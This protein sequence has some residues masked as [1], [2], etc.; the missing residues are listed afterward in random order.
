MELKYG[1]NYTDGYHNY[2]MNSMTDFSKLWFKGKSELI[3]YINCLCIAMNGNSFALHDKFPVGIGI[4]NRNFWKTKLIPSNIGSISNVENY[5]DREKWRNW[6]NYLDEIKTM[7]DGISVYVT[8]EQK[9]ILAYSPQ[10]DGMKYTRYMDVTFWISEEYAQRVHDS[11]VRFSKHINLL[12]GLLKH[13][14]L[15]CTGIN[16][17]YAHIDVGKNGVSFWPSS[18]LDQTSTRYFSEFQ[19]K[20]LANKF[21]CFVFANVLYDYIVDQKKNLVF[22][23]TSIELAHNVLISVIDTESAY[24]RL[25]I[26]F[27]QKAEN[28]NLNCW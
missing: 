1:V 20:P 6:P 14:P 22:Y 4:Y 10:Y 12:E 23:D 7:P 26:C 25:R 17:K 13:T 11:K 27:S 8:A 16:K 18:V 24:V 21:E 2:Y 5:H 3:E 9:S 15:Y 19:L 28:M